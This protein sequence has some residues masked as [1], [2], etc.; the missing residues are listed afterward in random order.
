MDTCHIFDEFVQQDDRC[1]KYCRAQTKA[2]T[3]QIPAAACRAAIE[4]GIDALGENALC[5][6][7]SAVYNAAYM[8]PETLLTVAAAVILLPRL[9]GAKKQSA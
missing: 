8:L 9:T 7:Y 2:D 6:L 3:Q 4:A 1:V 5:W